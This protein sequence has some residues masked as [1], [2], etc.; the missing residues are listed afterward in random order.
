MIAGKWFDPCIGIDIHLVIVPPSPSPVPLPHPFVG[1]V[2]DPAGLIVGAAISAGMSVIAGSPFTGPVLVNSLPAAT[3]GMQTTNKMTMPHIPTPPG[4]SFAKG[5]PENDGT[6]ITGSKT[7]HFSGPNAV[8]LGDL[9]M[10]CSEPVRLPSSTIIAIPMGLPVLVGGPPTL[11]IMAALMASLRSRWVSEQLHAL[12]G[13]AEGSWTSKIICFFTGHPVDVASGMVTTSAMDLWVPGPIPFKFERNYYSR[14]DYNGPLGHGWRHFYDQS[15]VMG[16]RRI[17]LKAGDGRDLY[18]HPPR[19]GETVRNRSNRL[20][21]TRTKDGFVVASSDHL[22]WHFT[23]QGR[24][25]G[26][27]PL[28]RVEDRNGNR[29]TL[30]YDAL[31]RLAEL[32][33]T[34]DRRFLFRNDDRGRVRSINGPHPTREGTRLDLLRFE[35]NQFGDLTAVYD[36][37]EHPRRYGYKN[38][39]LVQETDR[40]GL[41]FYFMYDGIDKDAWCVR[42]WGDGGIFDHVLTYDKEKHITVVEDSLGRKKT[43]FAN[44]AGVVEKVVDP[45]GGETLYEWDP[46][47]HK[48]A[49]TDPQGNTRKWT[50]D[51]LGRLTSHTDKAGDTV[52]LGYD[53]WGNVARVEAPDGSVARRTYDRRGNLL[54]LENATGPV[55]TFRYDE[56]GRKIVSTDALGRTRRLIHD[57][58]GQLVRWTIDEEQE[59]RCAYSPHGR[60]VRIEKIKGWW[61]EFAFDPKNRLTLVRDPSGRRSAYTYD[62]ENNVTRMIDHLGLATDYKYGHFNRI[63]Q[64]ADSAGHILRYEYDSEGQLLSVATPAGERYRF[65]YDSLGRMVEEET[66]DRVIRKYGYRDSH[67]VT[68]FEEVSS[69]RTAEGLPVESRIT[70]IERDPVGRPL[71]KTLADGEVHFF[72]YDSFGRVVGAST[73]AHTIELKYDAFGNVAEESQDGERV[74]YESDAFGR[75]LNR[76]TPAGRTITYSY[77]E[78]DKLIRVE[79]NDPNGRHTAVDFSFDKRGNMTEAAYPGPVRLSQQFEPDGRLVG[80]NLSG[81]RLSATSSFGYSEVGRVASIIETDGVNQQLTYD[82]A[83]RLREVS[84]A[85]KTERFEF[86][87]AGNLTASAE[88]RYTFG[89]GNRLATRDGSAYRYTGFGDVAERPTWDGEEASHQRLHYDSQHRLIRVENGSGE[90]LARYEYDAFGRRVKKILPDREIR[91]LWE[92]PCLLA[93]DDGTTRRE[94]VLNDYIPLAEANDR[95]HFY[96][97]ADLRGGT[98]F[99]TDAQGKVVWSGECK[100]FGERETHA[101]I[102]I[103]PFGLRGQYV[104]EETGLHYN[105][106]RYYDP[107]DA[108]F[109]TPDPIGLSGGKNPYQ[110]VGDP[111]LE[112]D[113]LGLAVNFSKANGPFPPPDFVGTMT[114]P[115]IVNAVQQGRNVAIVELQ[116]GTQIPFISGAAGHSEEQIIDAIARG[117]LNPAEVERIYS[118]LSPCFDTRSNCLEGIQDAFQDHDVNFEFSF[119]WNREGVPQQAK[120]ELSEIAPC[121][122]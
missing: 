104:D 8:R 102:M 79:M 63:V 74:R 81:S 33:D 88:A 93:E 96:Y 64:R 120:S 75:K 90:V 49:E 94:Y 85:E 23:P 58:H 99:V 106:L 54:R 97:H 4:V 61:H 3:T 55:Q 67:F 109:L 24:P 47:F 73:P 52:K 68:S 112:S 82:G 38:H 60:L 98:R 18:F 36:A 32:T 56:R 117:E 77:G 76:V 65:A 51:E 11:D 86:D 83:G 113:P 25:D 72:A 107:K 110:Y 39:L 84:S 35:Y 22:R 66:P 108:R 10:T 103:Q 46:W 28:A 89:G 21:L 119:P 6:I 43:Y 16:R 41:S 45:L 1:I 69:E 100:P 17:V 40:N 92:G 9:V 115:Q 2:Y 87:D 57:A 42:T 105:L 20:N 13:A 95:G 118:I 71:T 116:N 34:G 44:A 80:Q 59:Y 29:M 37:S 48:T 14:S 12:F 70:L 53:E 91:Y 62:A 31:G 78:A 5:M 15:I 26:S 27:L 122:R 111:F 121:G 114:Q 101:G 19:E 30:R 50:Y 7:V